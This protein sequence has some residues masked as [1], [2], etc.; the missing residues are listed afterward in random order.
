[1]S[2]QFSSERQMALER[3]E[4]LG[5]TDGQIAILHALEAWFN[6]N[7]EPP[8]GVRAIAEMAGLSNAAVGIALPVLE[9]LGYVHL[10]R[11]RSGRIRHRGVILLMDLGEEEI[12]VS[13]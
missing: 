11:E 13:F 6:E 4:R 9:K 2:L 5:L 1:M 12:D 8:K 7:P 3:V 10:N